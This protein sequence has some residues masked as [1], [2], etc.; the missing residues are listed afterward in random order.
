MLE[1]PWSSPQSTNRLPNSLKNWRASLLIAPLDCTAM[2]TDSPCDESPAYLTTLLD[3][4]NSVAAPAARDDNDIIAIIMCV[5]TRTF[6]QW[7]CC[8]SWHQRY[9]WSRSWLMSWLRNNG[10]RGVWLKTTT[11]SCIIYS[12]R[13]S[14]CRRDATASSPN[15]V[16]HQHWLIDC[17]FV[18]L[19][20]CFKLVWLGTSLSMYRQ[21]IV[22]LYL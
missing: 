22:P 1:Y 5:K 11:I 4:A 2:G 18:W 3:A 20:C 10:M 19:V 13:F 21:Y 9:Q 8:P 17:L 6:V 15:S 16:Y 12:K 7:W 14:W